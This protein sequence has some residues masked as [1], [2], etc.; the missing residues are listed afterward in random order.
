MEEKRYPQ[1]EEEQGMD[2]CCE[3]AEALAES[4]EIAMPEDLAYAHIID[5]V[6]QI[7]PDIEEEIEEVNSGDVV[8]MSQFNTMFAKW[9]V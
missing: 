5:N 9:L 3:P 7:T 6:L 4:V 8:N 1:I 2:I